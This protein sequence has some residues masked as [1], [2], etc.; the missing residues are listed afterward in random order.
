MKYKELRDKLR[1]K[2]PLLVLILFVIQPVLDTACYWQQQFGASNVATFL[3]RMLLLAACIL[4]G[5]CLSEHK[6][7]YIGGFLGLAALS[8]L[9][10]L[11]CLR[12]EYGYA[13]PIDDL[14]N[15]VRIYYLPVM[16]LCFVT[17]FRANE[18]A[19]PSA[20]KG[21]TLSLL[22][23]AAVQLVSSL[24]GTDP[25]T[26]S[27]HELGTLGWFLWT[28][29]QSAILAM[30]FPVAMGY[31]LKTRPEKSAPV[32]AIALIGGASLFVLGT[33]LSYASLFAAGVGMV[34]LLLLIDRKNWKKAAAL[35]LALCLFATIYPLSPV[36]RRG[37]VK[38]QNGD[39]QAQIDALMNEEPDNREKLEKLYLGDIIAYIPGMSRRF[40]T[41]RVM[42]AYEYSSDPAVL[43]D[44]RRA[45]L[46]YC[47]FLMEESTG[48]SRLFGLSLMDMTVRYVDEQGVEHMENFDPENDFHGIYYLLGAAGLLLLVLLLLA[49]GLRAASAV[50]RC[51]KLQLTPTMAGFAFAF[52]LA[53][54][55]AY[56]TA[57]IFRRPNAAI[58]L[59]AILAAL[60]VLPEEQRE[61]TTTEG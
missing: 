55:H 33:R 17:F 37:Q 6:I 42:E 11:A 53:V 18:R 21:M 61:K 60:W 22:I 41:E 58:Y 4:L 5:F 47:R 14:I 13:D 35:A 49:C 27:M 50:L 3:A 43:K 8:A 16:T 15:H 36:R 45:K 54:V 23:I 19:I 44:V 39:V 57:C 34:V 30:L 51:P 56:Y 24:T 20:M 59:A 26:Y 12:C 46:S 28:N 29:S 31:M 38:D 9:H 10:V 48:L 7:V 2:L 25:H 40:G 1:D 52:V 32:L